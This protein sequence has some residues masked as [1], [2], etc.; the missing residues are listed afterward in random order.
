[1]SEF[2]NPFSRGT[3][4]EVAVTRTLKSV[5]SQKII[6]SKKYIRSHWFTLETGFDW[7]YCSSYQII[8]Y[9]SLQ[10]RYW[11]FFG[12]GGSPKVYFTDLTEKSVSH[13]WKTNIQFLRSTGTYKLIIVQSYTFYEYKNGAMHSLKLKS[14]LFW[15]ILTAFDFVKNLFSP[16]QAKL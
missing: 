10:Y 2:C 1:M 5:T 13:I 11:C 9:M 15:V 16:A 12:L 3:T 6:V 8:L 7:Y 4:V 14:W